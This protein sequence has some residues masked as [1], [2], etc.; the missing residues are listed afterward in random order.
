MSSKPSSAPDQTARAV[1]LE[2]RFRR[3]IT[4]HRELGLRSPKSRREK[5]ETKSDTI[6]KCFQ[7]RASLTLFLVSDVAATPVI[8]A[9][10]LKNSMLRSLL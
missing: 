1:L 4:L 10:L 8:T 3:F 6:Y 9:R 2:D 7:V 5:L